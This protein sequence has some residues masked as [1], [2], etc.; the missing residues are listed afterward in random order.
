MSE[1]NIEK[2]SCRVSVAIFRFAASREIDTAEWTTG[3]ATSQR[4]LLDTR[5]WVDAKVITA[6]WRRLAAATDNPEIA[7]EVGVYAMRKNVL[8]SAGTIMRLFATMTRALQKAADLAGYFFSG[9]SLTP[10]RVGSSSALLELRGDNGAMSYHDL[11]FLRGVLA[12]LP[13]LWDL[14]MAR[15]E[16]TNYGLSVAECSPVADRMYLVDDDGGVHSHPS[17]EPDDIRDEGT[18]AEDGTFAVEEVCY[19]GEPTV[20]H[21]TWEQASGRSWLQRVFPSN[22]VLTETS[23]ALEK[24][25]R[26]LE[27]MYGNLEAASDDLQRL[28][29]LRTT[30][31]ERANVELEGLNEKLERQNRLKSEFIADFSHELRT[32][33]TS[34]VGFADL[35]DGGVF[36]A[37]NKRQANACQRIVVN[38]RVLLRAVND[39]LD[40]SKLQA[41]KMEVAYEEISVRD[42]L[43]ESA[44]IVAPLA[45]EKELTL[46]TEIG[47]EV[48][49]RIFTDRAKL[50]NVLVNLLGNAVKYTDRGRVTLRAFTAGPGDVSFAVE[51][52]GRGIDEVDLPLLFEEYALIG[53][54]GSSRR[55]MGLQIAKKLTALLR[56]SIAAGSQPGMGSEFTVTI[57][58][59]PIDVVKTA[60]PAS[61]S[62]HP[63]RA[64]YT[65]VVADSNA[66]DAVFL[67]LSFEAVG[68]RAE[69][70]TD[71]REAE[72]LVRQ[73]NADLLVL[74]PLLHHRDGW[75]VLQDLRRNS[76]TASLPVVLVSEN[77]QADLAEAYRVAG[78]FAKPYDR[79]VLVG[80]CL[81]L[82]GLETQGEAES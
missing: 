48:P 40:L 4:Q 74:D 55:G 33:I 75:Q 19:G 79:E 31:L 76:K 35:L 2:I 39:L 37:L 66:E 73:S 1:N 11:N 28:V 10:A 18:L 68:L 56:G 42:V 38:T 71:G 57:P 64:Q 12:G 63:E 22:D 46:K 59:R 34:I 62:L 72:R 8:G 3:L 17:G 36:G 5:R 13:L 80:E 77:V 21:V 69:T 44:A 61:E 52:T 27:A 26:D 51:D 16:I 78:V 45:E 7:A 24:D 49:T 53:S 47:P 43:D 41:G 82:L 54:G 65:I 30:E 70:C 58:V 60:A 29:A 23:A 15:V 67:R 20:L 6:L 25:L 50:K 32:L 9:V 14:P 81:R